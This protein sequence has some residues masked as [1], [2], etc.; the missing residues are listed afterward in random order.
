MSKRLKTLLIVMIVL[1]AF[2]LV[3]CSIL[4]F[5]VGEDVNSMIQV[6]LIDLVLEI[7]LAYFL[8]SLIQGMVIKNNE[9]KGIEVSTQK[10]KKTKT[11]IKVAFIVMLVIP[12]ILTSVMAIISI[13]KSCAGLSGTG[14][15]ES[16][17]TAIFGVIPIFFSDRTINSIWAIV[18]PIILAMVA[19]EFVQWLIK[20]IYVIIEE[21]F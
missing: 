4:P 7:P 14:S 13:L 20:K 3:E 8:Y 5:L 10:K 16:G 12:A 1:C 19:F 18:G 17:V 11:S 2:V 15:K 6:I 21:D 9:A